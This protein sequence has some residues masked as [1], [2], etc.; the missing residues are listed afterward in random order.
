M[1]LKCIE[2]RYHTDNNV[3]LL[4]PIL[5]ILACII[6]IAVGGELVVS[7]AKGIS[8]NVSDLLGIDRNM[9]ESF[10][11][12]TI[13]GVGTSLPELVTTVISSKKG[14]NEIALGNVIGSNIFNVIFV[15]GLSA[16]IAP[17]TVSAHMIIDLFILIFASLVVMF[18]VY[19]GKLN[20]KHSYLF[21]TMYFMYLVYLIIRL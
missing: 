12:L 4:K 20:R 17:Y 7:G 1:Y 11:G 2:S 13:V 15:A 5:L 6:G 21:L 8:M 10:V 3:K 14:E 9:A 16:V 18:F 19:R